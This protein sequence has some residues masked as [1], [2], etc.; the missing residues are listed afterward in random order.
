MAVVDDTPDFDYGWL[1]QNRLEL[2]RQIVARE[3]Q[4]DGLGKT[5]LS[6]VM[7]LLRDWRLILRAESERKSR[8]SF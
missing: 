3:N 5:R 7:A 2:Y 8:E 1:R 6:R 4:I